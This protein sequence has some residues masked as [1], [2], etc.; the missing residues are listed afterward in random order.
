MQ[1][2]NNMAEYEALLRALQK[3]RDSEVG[4]VCIYTDSLLL[5]NQVLGKYR[6]RN[7]KLKPYLGKARQLIAQLVRFDIRYVPRERNREADKL[8]KKAATVKG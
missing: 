1:L 3:A 5:A 2:T 4:N 8:A 7:E 6:T